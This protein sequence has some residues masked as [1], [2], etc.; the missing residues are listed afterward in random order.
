MKKVT[1]TISARITPEQRKMLT[2]L[3]KATKRKT[4]S[5]YLSYI[6]ETE[7]EK[8]LEKDNHK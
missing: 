1:T 2:E 8:L 5:D 6:I 7:Y 3:L 4:I